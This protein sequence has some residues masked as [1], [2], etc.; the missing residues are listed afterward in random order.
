[1]GAMKLGRVTG[2][3]AGA[4]ALVS[5]NPARAVGLVDRGEIAVGKR[6]DLAM[7]REIDGL[8]VVMGVWSAGRKVG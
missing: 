7:L 6:A 1:M 3:L 2:D 5:R 4:V 8:S